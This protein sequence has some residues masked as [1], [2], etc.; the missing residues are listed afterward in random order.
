MLQVRSVILKSDTGLFHEIAKDTQTWF[1]I[2][3]SSP[4]VTTNR[5][6]ESFKCFSQLKRFYEFSGRWTHNLLTKWDSFAPGYLK[7]DAHNYQMILTL[8]SLCPSFLSDP[9]MIRKKAEVHWCLP[10]TRRLVKSTMK[11]L[12]PPYLS[13]V[14]LG[15]WQYGTEPRW[16]RSVKEKHWAFHSVRTIQSA[17]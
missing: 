11:K 3:F 14:W 16:M 12:I 7:S 5:H 6:L 1:L 10:S 15:S 8:I 4:A 17:S 13:G 9:F 2:L